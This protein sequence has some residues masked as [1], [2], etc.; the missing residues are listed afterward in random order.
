[1]ADVSR[2]A[3][4]ILIRVILF[5]LQVLLELEAILMSMNAPVHLQVLSGTVIRIGQ[6]PKASHAHQ[7]TDAIVAVV[8]KDQPLL[9]NHALKPAIPEKM[10]GL[11]EQF[12]V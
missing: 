12:G 8:L 6:D 11:E 9:H 10:Q 1:M 3:A 2:Q 4:P 5:T 7:L